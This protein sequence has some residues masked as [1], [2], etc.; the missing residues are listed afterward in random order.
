MTSSFE[1]VAHAPGAFEFTPEIPNQNCRTRAMTP[2]QAGQLAVDGKVSDFVVLR[3][4]NLGLRMG[5]LGL[6]SIW[7]AAK[8]LASHAWD[9][10]SGNLTEG[11]VVPAPRG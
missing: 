1:S 4:A 8:G 5:G 7:G 9:A 6:L 10:I 3:S 11:A 2:S